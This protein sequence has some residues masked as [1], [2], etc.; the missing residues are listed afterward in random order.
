MKPKIKKLAH[1]RSIADIFS[2][3]QTE[4]DVSLL[5]SALENQ[6]GQYSIIGRSPYHKVVKTNEAIYLDDEKKEVDFATYVKAYFKENHQLNETG[7]PLVSGAI[8][9]FSYDY[10]R[11][12]Q[13]QIP[14]AMLIF[15][16]EFIIE[17]HEHRII[18]LI[19]NGKNKDADL[20]LQALEGEINQVEISQHKDVQEKTLKVTCHFEKEAYLTAIEKMM[21]YIVEGDIYIANMTQQLWLQSSVLPYDLYEILRAHNPAPFAAYLNYANFQV[22]CASPERFIQIKGRHIETRPIKGTRKRGTTVAEDV[23][24]MAELQHS[25][26]DKSELLM[27]VDLERND[28]NKICKPGS[29]R[30][31]E[32]YKIESY[33]TVHHLVAEVKGELEAHVDVMDMI[34][35]TFPG[36]S[37]TGAPKRRAMEIIEALE[38][39]DRG[40]YTGT[41]GYFSLNGDCDT[42]IVIRT[43]I[44]QDSVYQLGVGGGITYES[45]V[46]D[47]Y[48]ETLQKAKAFLDALS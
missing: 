32:L 29:V 33:A 11:N 8:G 5:E 6:L 22:V 37:I 26:K 2:L 34:H 16:D 10:N 35:A 19:A 13:G 24:M 43:A 36:G 21:A 31:E 18:Y 7:L 40:L 39:D 46:M 9:Y 42:N 17:D 23:Q 1:Y 3:Y 12:K 15:Y 25:E 47:E 44:Y 41:I 20:A 27:I 45:E 30:V 38:R 14:E 28:L 4:Q 48:E